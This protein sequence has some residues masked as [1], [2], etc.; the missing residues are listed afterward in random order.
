[1]LRTCRAHVRPFVSR[2]ALMAATLAF[3]IPVAGASAGDGPVGSTT[4]TST[5]PP[6]NPCVVTFRLTSSVRLTNID[7][8]VDYSFADGEFD[9]EF[10][11][12]FCRASFGG[13]LFAVRD[14]ENP[15]KLTV[16]RARI[17]K[18]QGPV[19]L[20]ACRF[21][22]FDTAPEV[23]DFSVTVTNA[24]RL[25]G[26][27]TIDIIPLPTARTESVEC[28]GVYPPVTTTTLPSTTTTTTVSTSTTTF[29]PSSTTTLPMSGNCATPISGGDK[30]TASDALFVLQAGVGLKAC[31]LCL[32]DADGNGDVVA[33]DA[34]VA[35]R[36]SV[37][38]PVDL[39]CPPCDP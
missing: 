12:V 19:D 14:F 38:Q 17:D 32:C 21:S 7:F 6:T 20:M 25:E 30:P 26:L 29:F 5:L 10:Q 4:T 33:S 34:L 35:L 11:H 15:R 3:L 8:D 1:M 22:F 39:A 18:F 23:S 24:A 36:A 13:G 16:A 28:P 2:A 9:G 31:A 37:N 27:D